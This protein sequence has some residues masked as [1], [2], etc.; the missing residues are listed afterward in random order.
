MDKSC[1]VLATVVS[2]ILLTS[3]SSTGPSTPQMA[4]NYINRQ[5]VSTIT[6]PPYPAKN[7]QTVSLY[8][9]DK[10][11]HTAY[12]VIGTAKVY[13]QNLLGMQRQNTT[14]EQMMKK[15]AASIGGDGLINVNNH[16]DRVEAKVIAFQ[17]ILI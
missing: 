13:K 11:P 7:P 2:T 16:P 1:T 3:C 4:A 5:Q 15:L 9:P 6:Q 17:K 8:T 12:R 10:A 14:I